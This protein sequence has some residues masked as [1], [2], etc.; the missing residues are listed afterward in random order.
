MTPVTKRQIQFISKLHDR[1][2]EGRLTWTEASSNRFQTNL[3]GF[4]VEVAEYPNP[5][6]PEAID[7]WVFINNRDGTR[8]ESIVDTDF[9]DIHHEFNGFHAMRDTYQRARRLAL[10]VD[11]AIDAILA[12]LESDDVNE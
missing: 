8:I 12:A 4:D 3:A 6:D 11:R 10:G 1:T 5:D 2:Q 9:A 7:Y